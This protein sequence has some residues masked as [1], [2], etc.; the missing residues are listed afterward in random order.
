[1]RIVLACLMLQLLYSASGKEFIGWT[2]R[3]ERRGTCKSFNIDTLVHN[4]WIF[5]SL[6]IISI[7]QSLYKPSPLWRSNF[8]PRAVI[9]RI[10][11]IIIVTSYYIEEWI[12]TLFCGY[13]LLVCNYYSLSTQMSN[14][15]N[16]ARKLQQWDKLSDLKYQTLQNGRQ[17]WLLNSE[18]NWLFCYIIVVSLKTTTR[19][20]ITKTKR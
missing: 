6:Y 12:V 13:D 14:N 8:K 17:P 11:K 7:N 10:F 5:D 4:T 16:L 1:M 3:P 18:T 2:I 15:L 9:D 19:D 20:H